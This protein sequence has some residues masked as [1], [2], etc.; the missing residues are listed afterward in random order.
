MKLFLSFAFCCWIFT[1]V[2]QD[3]ENDGTPYQTFITIA[4]DLNGDALA[5]VVTVSKD[6]LNRKA[7]YCLRVYFAKDK[8]VNVLEAESYTVAGPEF[9]YDESPWNSER[10]GELGIFKNVLVVE[11]Q[12]GNVNTKYK[13]RYQNSKFEL[14]GYTSTDNNGITSKVVDFN[15]STGKCVFK[16]V[17]V[18]TNKTT[19]SSEK[20][21]PVNPLPELV[22]FD[23]KPVLDLTSQK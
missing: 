14:I 19:D 18:A 15:L 11:R 22:H 10:H 23:P 12:L 20:K 5:D 7:P 2:A 21:I 16:T 4:G 3:N 6:T 17:N 8:R 9:P 1:A 13:F